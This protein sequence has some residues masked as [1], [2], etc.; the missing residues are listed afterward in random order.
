MD[1]RLPCGK[2]HSDNVRQSD[3][4]ALKILALDTSTE[5]CSVALSIDGEADFRGARAGQTH[6]QVVLRMVD[7]LLRAHAVSLHDLDGIAYGEGP[8]SFTGLRIACGVVQGLAF[9][10]DLRVVGVGTLLAMAVGT[11]SKRVVC[12]L[13]ARMQE[14]YHAA[15]EY[16]LGSWHVVHAPSVCPPAA[17]PAL[18]GGGWLGCG[19]GFLA[20]AN[21]LQT[22]YVGQLDAIEPD[23]YPHA[24][25]IAQL[26]LPRFRANEAVS[27]EKAAPLYLRDKVALRTDERAGR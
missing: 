7:E 4:A 27:S 17:A 2:I 14:I 10:A 11:G 19:S 12:C 13:D 8:G 24:R 25:E 15:Y 6:S 26:A 18:N 20:H 23:R 3:P 22:S 1:L 5:Y 21:V 16:H 9:G